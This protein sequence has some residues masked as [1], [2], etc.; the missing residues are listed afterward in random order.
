[1]SNILKFKLVVSFMSLTILV[2]IPLL[3]NNFNAPANLIKW[4]QLTWDDF[5]GIVRPFTG[6][7]AAIGSTIYVEYDS[8]ANA[9]VAYAVMSDRKSWT[10]ADSTDGSYELNHEQYHF[11]ISEVHAR[12]MNWFLQNNPGKNEVEYGKKLR[13]L[14]EELDI[15]QDVYDDET[16]HSLNRD[17]QKRWE[18]KIDSMLLVFSSDSGRITDYYSG[19]EVF[20]PSAPEFYHGI[21]SALYSY[22][23]LELNKYDLTFTVLSFQPFGSFTNASM[24]D[25][26]NFYLQD[27]LEIMAIEVDSTGDFNSF[28]VEVFDSTTLKYSHELWYQNFDYRY[29]ALAEYTVDDDEV[30]SGYRTMALSFLN[31]F[32]VRNTNRY[33]EEKMLQSEDLLRISNTEPFDKVKDEGEACFFYGDYGQ[34]GFLRGPFY[35]SDGGL[36]LAYDFI[37]HP[38]SEMH[39]ELAVANNR[40]YLFK[41]GRE[42]HLFHIP[43]H[44]IPS[45]DFQLYVGYTLTKDTVEV[46][47]PY[48]YSGF[49][50]SPPKT[51]AL[52]AKVEGL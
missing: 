25:I 52:T 30:L 47:S 33:W 3:K 49:S 41:T 22:R 5:K 31:S 36:L 42:D 21:D 10:K 29:R 7:Y 50:I 39:E 37:E 14:R 35:G 38:A 44:E 8:L 2:L 16:D 18:Y 17:I 51:K 13:E 48:Y 9:Y 43:A 4:R 19:A 6:W 46:C 26:T 45:Y 23:S 27:S 32:S 15:M 20:F 24:K 28:R 34:H 11:N 1:M 40:I 12:K